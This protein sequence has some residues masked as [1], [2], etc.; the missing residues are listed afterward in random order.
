MRLDPIA[1]AITHRQRG[2]VSQCHQPSIAVIAV[3]AVIAGGVG[4]GDNGAGGVAVASPAVPGLGEVS[5]TSQASFLY[6]ANNS[7]STR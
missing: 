1:L 2:G 4:I 7:A 5:S 3:I 6:R